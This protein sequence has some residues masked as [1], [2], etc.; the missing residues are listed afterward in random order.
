MIDIRLATPQDVPELAAMKYELFAETFLKGFKIPYPETDLAIFVQESYAQEAVAREIED[1]RRQNWVVE[2]AGTLIGYAQC[3]SCKLPH[4]ERTEAAGE[5][6][7]LYFRSGYQGQGLGSRLIDICAAW[8]A[9]HYP[10]PLWL[11]VWSG[12]LQAQ[13]F[14]AKHGFAKVGEYEYPVGTWRDREFIFRRG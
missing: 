7:Q 3:G 4:P 2:D 5:L 6:Y 13:N 10:G 1:A 14:Y 8:L 12:N 11:G 9:Q